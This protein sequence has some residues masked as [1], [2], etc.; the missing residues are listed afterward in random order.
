MKK[1]ICFPIV[2]C[3]LLAPLFAKEPLNPKRIAELET[4]LSPKAKGYGDPI[5]NRLVWDNP[6]IRS[7][8]GAS[9]MI[10]RAETLVKGTYPAWSDDDYLDFSK[11]GKRPR[12]EVMLKN[13]ISWLQPLVLAELFENRGRF[14]PPIEMVLNALCDQPTWTLPAHDRDLKCFSR[15]SYFAELNGTAWAKDLAETIYLLRP[16]LTKKTYEKVKE[17]IEDRILNPVRS[18]RE[19]ETFKHWWMHG[20]N[21]WNIVCWTGVLH[22]AAAILPDVKDR[23]WF[24]AAAEEGV[25]YYMD[26]QSTDGYDGEGAGYW[27]Y[28]MNNFNEMREMAWQMTS[29][30]LDF[31]QTEKVKHVAL[32]GANIRLNQNQTPAYGDCRIGTVID[33]RAL[34]Y[35]NAAI[36][37]GLADVPLPPIRNNIS[38]L[39]CD[40][41]PN[42]ISQVK[43]TAPSSVKFPER[44]YFSNS[45]VLVSRDSKPGNRFSASFKCGVS[46]SHKHL[47]IGSFV[48]DYGPYHIAGDPGGPWAY[49]GDMSDKTKRWAYKSLSSFG[50][51]VPQIGDNLQLNSADTKPVFLKYQTDDLSEILSFDLTTAYDPTVVK[52]WIRTYSFSRADQGKVQIEDSLVLAHPEIVTLSLPT[53]C[54]V[55]NLS[56]NQLQLTA[57]NTTYKQTQPGNYLLTGDLRPSDRPS[58]LLTVETPDGFTVTSEDVEVNAPMFHRYGLAL[59]KP[60]EKVVT[61]MIFTPLP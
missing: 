40:L 13:R 44:S 5:N 25:G 10:S 26:A 29:G 36:G 21:N 16:V 39:S 11:T 22:A 34:G 19:S 50:H 60:R 51:P 41:F 42:S 33:L 55:T 23:A 49:N 35:L 2:G 6:D 4:Q 38:G 20:E 52:Q 7:N 43:D 32:F 12:G 28:T 58:V 37:L 14:L 54:D 46:T 9:A 24:L 27:A 48:I 18:D 8:V 59:K 57:V 3:L 17:A 30:K 53:F 1:V 31:Y 56:A 45:F 15:E 61:K 47:D